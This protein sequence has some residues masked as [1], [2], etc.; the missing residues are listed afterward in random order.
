MISMPEIPLFGLLTKEGRQRKQFARLRDDVH[1]EMALQLNARRR[2]NPEPTP[3]EAAV[4]V[5]RE[6]LEP[7]VRDAV[8]EFNRKGYKTIS[9]GFEGDKGTEYTPEHQVIGGHFLLD[10]ET[11]QKLAGMGI[12]VKTE[13]WWKWQMDER[14][15]TV[16][17]QAPP[18]ARIL[19][20]LRFRPERPDLQEM[21][22]KWKQ[23]AGVLP[24][25]GQPALL[26]GK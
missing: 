6:E 3:E 10:D 13:P 1:L 5:L 15:G 11:K 18:E 24:D 23:I 17:P 7:Q 22:A 16:D 25:R 20:T 2:N 4:G 21:E 14:M 19:T 8:F 9:S 12:E 26:D